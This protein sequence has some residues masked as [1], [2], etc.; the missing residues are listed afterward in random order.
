[1]IIAMKNLYLLSV[2]LFCLLSTAYGQSGCNCSVTVADTG[3]YDGAKMGIQP[4]ATVCI[5]ARTYRFLRFLNFTGT[6]DRP[7]TFVNCGGVAEVN[8]GLGDTT[9]IAFLECKYFRVTGTGD[10]RYP[11]GILISKTDKNTSGL[12]IT[13][14]STDCE[15]DHIEV[16]N[17]G[18]AGIMIKTDPTCDPTTWRANFTMYNVK[19]HDNYVH[20]TGGEGLYIG[21]SFWNNGLS[22]NCGNNVNRIYPHNI[23]GLEISYNRVEN[24]AAEGIQYAC[25]PNSRVH[26]NSVYGAGYRPF[27]AYQSNGVQIGGGVSGWFYNNTIRKSRATG[28][29]IVGHLGPNYIYNNVITDAGDNAVFIDER[30]GTIVGAEEV[31]LNNTIVTAKQEGFLLYNDTQKN[32]IINNAIV[33][34]AKNKFIVPISKKMVY[35]DQN[36][37]K[38][39]VVAD[40]KFMD[41]VNYNFRPLAGSP[42]IDAGQDVSRYGVLTDLDDNPRPQGGVYD[43]GAYEYKGGSA[44]LA[45]SEAMAE[46]VLQLY[47]SPVIDQL[48]VQLPDQ[49]TIVSV[50]LIDGNGRQVGY[51]LPSQV[52]SRVN[53]PVGQLSRGLYVVRVATTSQSFSGR[54][55]KE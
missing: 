22:R 51:H 49:T 23:V 43:I 27:A 47:P 18:F 54:F 45:V 48:T 38:S 36:N 21:N 30:T 17:T 13:R 26:H 4:G 32:I 25:A 3:W 19:V 34:V 41:A 5:K 8:Y 35:T 31:F 39:Y 16:A 10:S 55:V 29:I 33:A 44:R 40:A 14:R 37:F 2:L 9:G 28:L 7:I 12:H 50:A 15:V 53:L 42:L 46:P 6:P 24:S 1:M 11:Y 52:T 20:D